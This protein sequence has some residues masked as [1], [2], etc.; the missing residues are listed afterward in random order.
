MSEYIINIEKDEYSVVS[1]EKTVTINGTEYTYELV[2]HRPDQFTLWL[3]SKVYEICRVLSEDNHT[4]YLI[5]GQYV[6]AELQSRIEKM[7]SGLTIN[8]AASDSK[9][10][11]K[12]P[13]PGMVVKILKQV[14]DVVQKGEILVILEAMKMENDIKS[15][16]DG[17][18][19]IVS[20]QSGQKV[21]KGVQLMIIE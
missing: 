20:A 1:S 6:Q 7:I 15:P 5:N 19:S 3:G 9:V 17:K 4:I 16:K 11:I 18:I 13:M 12:S 10:I 21:E 8:Q 14:G 2:S